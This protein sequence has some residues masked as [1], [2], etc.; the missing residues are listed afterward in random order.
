MQ[1]VKGLSIRSKLIAILL[2]L[3][4][5]SLSIGFTF[6][7]THDIS[8]FRKELVVNGVTI[9]RVIGD[10]SVVDLTFQDAE[11]SKATLAKLNSIQSVDC[12]FLYDASGR[13]FSTYTKADCDSSQR[14][15]LTPIE[16]QDGFLHLAQRIQDKERL[17]GTIYMRFSV[18]ELNRKINSYLATMLTLGVA[19][20]ILSFILAL[21]LQRV[22]SKPLIELAEATQ[23]VSEER[24]YSIRMSTD[25]TDEVGVLFRGFNRMLSQIEKRKEERDQAERALRESEYRYRV[26]VESSPEAMFLEQDGKIL[27]VNPVGLNL[28]GYESLTDLQQIPLFSLLRHVPSPDMQ[29]K[30]PQ[31]NILQR[32]DGTQRDVEIL[33]V[34]TTHEGKPA[35]QYLIRDITE[36]KSLRDAAE[37]MERL[38][39][40]GEFSAILAH[41]IR[42]AIGSVALNARV[43]A[44][45]LQVPDNYKKNLQNMELG[46][47]RTQEIIRAILDFARPAKPY[48]QK[49][50]INKAVESSI[51]LVEETLCQ[52]G[53][54]IERI[55]DKAEPIVDV[56]V[57][58]IGQVLTNLLLNARNA[59][60]HGGKISIKTD[61]RSAEG[62]V[63]LEVAD[64]GRGI[65]REHL[66]KIFN[67]FFTTTPRG[68]GLGLAFVSRILEQHD[69]QIL[70]DS[71]VGTGTVFTIQ[72]RTSGGSIGEKQ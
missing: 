7:I 41:E 5:I 26:L 20:I 46:M 55:F 11:A 23:R 2:F 69:A 16:F 52:A 68:V 53:I 47:Q 60:D 36:S 67:P 13:L 25:S 40:I 34:Y 27:Y 28:T 37:R 49:I 58:Q 14:L 22:I 44:D 71:K 70:V 45:R 6:V 57:N 17:Y 19:L 61:L 9:A 10:Y 35:I 56:D 1:I 4:I 24:D 64:T 33:K 63:S 43:L 30:V 48:K 31:E 65:P 62:I 72:F 12:A 21:Q 8:T 15:R 42:N 50:S 54:T 29:E 18:A 51:H 3:S 59:M 38:A 39:A 66:S 32:N